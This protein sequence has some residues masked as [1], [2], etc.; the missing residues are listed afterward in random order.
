MEFC[1]GCILSSVYFG[2][3]NGKKQ[4]E[5]AYMFYR[6]INK[7]QDE[8]SNEDA[9]NIVRGVKNPSGYVID[10]LG[11]LTE[12]DYDGIV[13]FFE[14]NIIS[15]IK[16]NDRNYVI[17]NI[18][19]M[20][21]ADDNIGQDTIV[22]VI[23]K[24]SKK[25]ISVEDVEPASFLAGVYIY[26]LKNT[27]NNQDGKIKEYTKEC[28]DKVVNGEMI[29]DLTSVDG[30]K[31][32]QSY[33]T[34]EID[35]FDE[36]I[37]QQ[38]T[39]FC[40][41]HD[42]EK[43]LIPLCQIAKIT[44]QTHKHKRNM[45]N[46]YCASTKSVQ[47]RV[48][49]MKNVDFII[50]EKEDLWWSKYLGKFEDD[51]SKY[52]LGTEDIKYIFVQYFYKLFEYADKSISK[53]TEPIFP[54]KVKTAVSKMAPDFKHDVRGLIGEYIFYSKMDEYRDVLER[55]MNYMWN[56]LNFGNCSEYDLCVYIALF[57]IG[58]CYEIPNEDLGKGLFVY[59]APSIFEIDTAEDLFYLTLL[60][61]YETYV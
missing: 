11:K 46:E 35:M 14:E 51:Y 42:E 19:Y 24:I 3:V 15:L 1:L 32:L 49:E 4:K 5:I 25:D 33:R 59:E 58:T 55:P 18:I 26:A 50:D 41:E 16:E 47:N 13:H 31:S 12:D 44:N 22:D 48:L 40:I 2:R 27:K 38:A 9:S 10:E 53:Y 17:K 20:I 60:I 61:L 34:R 37:E 28:W 6:S 43:S 39:A 57:I 56:Y 30:T 29:N 8:V 21:N 36:K 54:V 23:N 7:N 52:Q 45:Y